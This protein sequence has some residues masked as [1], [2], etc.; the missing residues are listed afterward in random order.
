MNKHAN[1]IPTNII[2]GFLGVGKTTAI[3]G[4]LA[5]KPENESWA[6]LVNEFG[7]IG[8]DQ[9]MMVQG[10]GLHVKE[11][12]GGCICCALGPS[13]NKTLKSL[14]EHA[15]PDRLIIEPTGLGHP[16]GII[17]MLTGA[18]FDGQLDLRATVCLLDPREL[19]NPDV[20]NNPVFHDQ[21]NLAD[22]VLLN[23]CDVTDEQQIA[24]V[25]SSLQNMFPVRQHVGRTAR[26]VI[27]PWLLD[28]VRNGQLRAQFPEAHSHLHHN[29]HHHDHDHDHEHENE[30]V[31]S[32]HHGHDGHHHS[33]LHAH[34]QGN[35]SNNAD[36]AGP[37]APL[38]K[39]G[40]GSGMFSCGW[41]F[42]RNDCFDYWKLA[43]ILN[44]L[45]SISRIK[46]VINIGKAWVFYNRVNNEHDF[47][48]VAYRRDSRI[49]IISTEALNWDEIEA[50]MLSCR[51]DH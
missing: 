2:T 27:A 26:G 35:I 7:Q 22:V 48:K 24:D 29:H 4:L 25:E 41:V 50:E 10:D 6:V 16:E 13:L 51:V 43:D 19:A 49:E 15:R 42:H 33:A 44:N 36:V 38:R 46:G 39:T 32:H 45:P 9:E 11:L 28:V 18:A 3:N 17:D 30:N 47:D 5:T 20:I 40:E 8:I 34:A 23:K 31:H 12:T 1:L 14:I 21:L 37:G